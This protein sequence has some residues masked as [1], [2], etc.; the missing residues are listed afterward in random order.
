M[1]ETAAGTTRQGDLAPMATVLAV[2]VAETLRRRAAS[3]RG[4]AGAAEATTEAVTPTGW[5]AA[6]LESVA[7]LLRPFL[8]FPRALP[9]RTMLARL[10]AQ[11]RP[12]R[13]GADTGELAQA[14]AVLL[15]VGAASLRVLAA[16][17]AEAARR[18]V[19]AGLRGVGESDPGA[20]HDAY[21]AR[22]TTELGAVAAAVL[23]RHRFGGAPGLARLRTTL[24]ELTA[25]GVAWLARL[26]VA[27]RE[28]SAATAS[29]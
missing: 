12:A 24:L 16:V 13:A 9:D 22:L 23:E 28:A 18:P 7:D 25:S 10:L 15:G 8:A 29:A 2:V 20:E 3:G 4:G 11:S 5:D 19:S 1:L 17:A 14:L 27:S 26:D 6:T 21:L